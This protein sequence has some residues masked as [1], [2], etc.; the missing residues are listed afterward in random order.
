MPTSLALSSSAQTTHN[1]SQTGI[2]MWICPSTTTT[3]F[4]THNLGFV[5]DMM[6]RLAESIRPDNQTSHYTVDAF[7]SRGQSQRQGL[8]FGSFVRVPVAYPTLS[9]SLEIKRPLPEEGVRWLFLRSALQWYEGG[10]WDMEVV[11]WDQDLN[12]VA[13]S[14]L[15]SLVVDLTVA[16]NLARRRAAAEVALKKGVDKKLKLEKL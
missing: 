5:V 2:E 16:G 6:P 14:R 9:L 8:E 10:K 11:V 1:D 7:Y 15:L 13:T 12:I 3:T 4:K